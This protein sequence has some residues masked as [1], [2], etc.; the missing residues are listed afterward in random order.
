MTGVQTCALPIW[1]DTG[2]LAIHQEASGY[3]QFVFDGTVANPLLQ[4]HWSMELQ[5]D[6]VP[7]ELLDPELPL[8][9]QGA[10][11]AV[12]DQSRGTVSGSLATTGRSGTAYN[13]DARIDLEA[14]LA[15]SHLAIRQ[16]DLAH[17]EHSTRLAL[18]GGIAADLSI[19][20]TGDWEAL[21]WPLVEEPQWESRTGRLAVTGTLADYRVD[22]DAQIGG[23]DL[24]AGQWSL[25]GR[26]DREQLLLEPL[27]GEL[28][29]GRLVTRGRI[30]WAPSLSW[31]LETDGDNL[32]LREI[33]PDLEATVNLQATTR[34]KLTAQGAEAELRLKQLEGSVQG[35]PLAATGQLA[36]A[37]ERVDIER[38]AIRSG[39]ASLVARGVVGEQSDLQWNLEIPRLGQLL[40]DARGQVAGTGTVQGP[41]TLPRLAGE[42]TSTGLAYQGT[43][44]E[45][46]K[47]RLLLDM[48]K[49]Q[50]SRI[51]IEGSVLSSNDQVLE[52][53]SIAANGPLAEH[54]IQ[55]A[56]AH[57]DGSLQA[58]LQGGFADSIW[59]GTVQQFDLES[60]ILGAWQLR[61]PTELTLGASSAKTD[62][63]CLLRESSRICIDGAWHASGEAQASFTLTALPLDWL[64]PGLRQATHRVSGTLNA[65]GTGRLAPGQA[66]TADISARVTPGEWIV[67]GIQEQQR[68]PHGGAELA[69]RAQSGGAV[70][71]LTAEAGNNTLSANLAMPDLLSVDDYRRAR[72]VA[73]IRIEAPDLAFLPLLAPE[74]SNLDGSVSANFEVDGP[75][76]QPTVRGGGKLTAA[77]LEIEELGIRLTDTR[78][79]LEVAES[80]LLLDGKL[81]A[82][83]EAQI[84]GR[85]ALDPEQGWPLALRLSGDNLA[86]IDLP[87]LQI[88]VSPDLQ[89]SSEADHM[90]LTGSVTVPSADIIV[91]DLP[92]ESRSASSDVIVLRDDMSPSE[93]TQATVPVRLDVGVV[94]GQSVHVSALGLNALLSGEVAL[95][96]EPRQPVLASGDIRINEGT[97]RAFNQNLEITRGII[98]YARSPIDNPGL[99]LQATRSIGEVVVGVNALGTAR[100]TTVT[101]FSSPAMSEHDRLSY[102]LTGSAA[103]EGA[104]LSLNRQ[105][106]KN[107]SLGISVDT[108]TGESAFVTRYRINRNFHSEVTSGANSSALDLFFTVET[109]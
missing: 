35:Y 22:L 26:G 61:Q 23:R 89:L 68:I 48:A 106:D 17:R 97:F 30:T 78:L 19:D 20:I 45:R 41:L 47:T 75:L 64:T 70:G 73:D 66:P 96:A 92:A 84:N 103:G 25:A 100:R 58:L 54:K 69:L 57:S 10:L 3:L 33:L 27:S 85:L 34:G 29:T 109:E 76:S 55:L 50:S 101:T 8:L 51:E 18:S 39:D 52:T 40:A 4:P 16:F 7:G 24:P 108:Q 72:L 44:V 5:L 14:D 28:L 11:R 87:N 60:Q 62:P 36:Y 63:I 6:E 1:G 88:V 94:L 38:L 95:R 56:A 31:D 12:G 77:L 2:Q 46:L 93:E 15:R 104:S 102:L 42:I 53:F 82:G 32:A 80:S 59:L 98:S 99:N 74:I 43:A 49:E 37:N 79:N 71:S 105:I 107:I 86:L 90:A 65:N 21:R 81:S 67:T 83:G 13:L 91:R 9:L